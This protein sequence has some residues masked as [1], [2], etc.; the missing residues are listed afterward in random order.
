MI[1]LLSWRRLG[2]GLQR[3]VTTRRPSPRQLA[4]AAHV[5]EALLDKVR[6]DPGARARFPRRLWNSGFPQVLTGFLAM[7]LVADYGLPV[8]STIWSWL[9]G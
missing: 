5:G 1:V 9:S 7:A 6:A 2:A 4:S 8:L 3:W